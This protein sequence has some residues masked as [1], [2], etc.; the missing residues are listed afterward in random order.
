[1]I[2]ARRRVGKRLPVAA[3]SSLAVGAAALCVAVLAQAQYI[4]IPDFSYEPPLTAPAPAPASGEMCNDCGIIRSIREIQIQRPI[5]VPGPFQNNPV[6]QGMGSTTIVGAIVVL[7]IGAG[8]GNS[9][10]GGV[11]TPE[12]RSRFLESSYEITVW[13]DN[14]STT[15][16]QRSDGRHYRVG[17]RVRVEGIQLYLLT[18]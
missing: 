8:S 3:C 10:V 16:L 5:P 7:P 15:V 6:N 11:G 18:P 9:Y 4:K 2:L 14:G 12:M 1:M 13:L 17:D